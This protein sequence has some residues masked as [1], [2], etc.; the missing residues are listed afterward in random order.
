MKPLIFSFL[1]LLVIP[2][3]FVSAIHSKM[4]THENRIMLKSDKVESSSQTLGFNE[5]RSK[6]R[7]LKQ[8]LKEKVSAFLEIFKG[9]DGYGLAGLILGLLSLT[10]AGLVLGIPAIILS[11]G[12]LKKMRHRGDFRFKGFAISGLILGILSTLTLTF[13][14]TGFVVF[15]LF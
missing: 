15:H 5:S 6:K 4:E 8:V 3:G 10:G 11:I 14:A 13:L 9:D 7:I 2:V 1:I 12:A